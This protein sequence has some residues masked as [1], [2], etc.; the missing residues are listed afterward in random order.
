MIDYF[1]TA[2]LWTAALS[3]GLIAGIYFALSRFIMQAFS[4][5]EESCS[6]AAMNS[7]NTTIQRSLFMPLF[8]GST[9]VSLLLVVVALLRWGET[10]AAGTLTAG[11]IYFLG[12]F[13]CTVLF[14]VPLN[15]VLAGVIENGSDAHRVWVHYLK[16]W[17]NWNH[18]RT[19]SSMV[20]CA[21]CIWILS[22]S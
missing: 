1:T 4:R 17:T 19:V 13:A 22:G 8:F 15:N 2:L 6:I 18:L 9:I 14:N 20:T 11:A 21:I 3:S 16:T 5:I 7:I 10:G 12:M